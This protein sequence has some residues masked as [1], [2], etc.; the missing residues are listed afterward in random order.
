MKKT[1]LNLAVGVVGVASLA[2]CNAA[3][4]GDITITNGSEWTLDH[5]YIS[6]A[7]QAEWGPDQLG[8]ETIATGETYTLKGV[9]CAT[10]DVKLIDEDGDECEVSDVDICGN[11]G[12]EI[13]SDDLLA[14]QSETAD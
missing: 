9:P 8:D 14:C 12:W 13:D 6:A 7:N 11:G 5:L 3:F 2:L 4:A 10:Y 1:I